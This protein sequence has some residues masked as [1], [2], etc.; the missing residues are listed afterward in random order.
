MPIIKSFCHLCHN[1][2]YIL[3]SSFY[4]PIHLWAVWCRIVMFD[5][6]LLTY[7]IHHFVV[8]VGGIIRNDPFWNSISTYDLSFDELADH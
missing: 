6:E 3:V 7:L 1:L 5:L 4:C 8:Q 2:L